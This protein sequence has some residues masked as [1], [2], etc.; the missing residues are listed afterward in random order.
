[1]GNARASDW[2]TY[3]VPVVGEYRELR[4]EPDALAS[5][6]PELTM[7]E[8]RRLMAA[9][10]DGAWRRLSIREI[11]RAAADP[12]PQPSRKRAISFGGVK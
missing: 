5:D 6:M 12:A 3:T 11:H 8:L 9:I 10:E 7:G 1:M 2:A 4:I